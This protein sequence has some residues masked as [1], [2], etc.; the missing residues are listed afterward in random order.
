ML[1]LIAT[2]SELDHQK[3]IIDKTA[4]EVFNEHKVSI[5]YSVGTMIELP[6]AA[7]IADQIAKTAEFFSFGTNDLTQTTY[8]IS[9]DDSSKF[10]PL[11]VKGVPH[12]QKNEVLMH[13]FPEDPFQV[14]D[15]EGV[16]NL[17]RFA[18]QLGRKVAPRLSAAFVE[19]MEE[20]L[21]R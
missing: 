10:V 11:Y 1:P 17:M 9:R 7:L 21:V 5:R 13:I 2:K 4:Q 8:G 14:L 15:R 16:G 12:P 19:N 3:A 18:V 6:R 20:N